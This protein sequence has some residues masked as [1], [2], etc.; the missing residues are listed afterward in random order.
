MQLTITRINKI[1]G[2]HKK[3]ITKKVYKIRDSIEI[4]ED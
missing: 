4:Y 2:Y 1:Q 3:E